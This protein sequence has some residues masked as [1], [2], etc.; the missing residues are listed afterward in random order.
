LI[1]I[2]NKNFAAL[3]KNFDEQN[4]IEENLNET[5]VPL[6]IENDYLEADLGSGSDESMANCKND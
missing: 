3:I 1:L 6:D 2:L 5:E 4:L